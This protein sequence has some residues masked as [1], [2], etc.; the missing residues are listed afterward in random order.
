MEAAWAV[1]LGRYSGQEDIVFGATVSGHAAAFERDATMLGLFINNLPVRTQI[2]PGEAFLAWAK[3]FQERTFAQRRYEHIPVAQIQQWSEI[4]PGSRLFDSILVVNYETFAMN[5]LSQSLEISD[6]RFLGWTNFPLSLYIVL[7]AHDAVLRIKYDCRRF[8]QT[9][10]VQL[11]NH[12]TTLLENIAANPDQR[13]AALSLLNQTEHQRLLTEWNPVHSE[14]TPNIGIHQI[15][16]A[17]AARTPDAV[18]VLTQPASLTYHEL[19]QRANRLA[20]YLQAQRVRPETPIALYIEH[21]PEIVVGLLG[22]WKSGGTLLPLDPTHPADYITALLED[23]QV[24]IVVT[25]HNLAANLPGGVLVIALDTDDAAIARE[26]DDNPTSGVSADN[27]AYLNYV[28]LPVGRPGGV[29]LEHRALH[30]LARTQQQMFEL[31]SDSRILMVAPLG[32]DLALFELVMA[33]G[34]GATLCMAPQSALLPGPGLARLLHEQAITHITLSA[35]AL[36]AMPFTELPALRTIAL[37]EAE[38]AIENLSHWMAKYHCF[39][40]YGTTETTVC[41]TSAAGRADNQRP[42]IGRPVTG[43]Q[44]YI[45]DRYRQLLPVGITGELYIG[46][47]GLARGYR[48]HPALTAG[49]FIPHP[50]STEPGARLYRTGD[51]AR[52]TPD[53]TIELLGRSDAQVKLRGLRA[54]PAEVEAILRRHP[55][56]QQAA[57]VARADTASGTYLVA[58]LV[59]VEAEPGAGI[60]QDI[61]RFLQTQLPG[62]MTPDSMLLLESLPCTG[63][64]Q[65]DYQALPTPSRT[66]PGLA[67][68]Y[69]APRTETE[70]TI[71]AIWQQM[72]HID[73][74]GVDDNF[75][76]LG[77]HSLLMVQVHSE[78]QKVFQ[79]DI[80]IVELFNYATVGT[81]ANYLSQAQ[82]TPASFEQSQSRAANR[83]ESLLQ[84]RQIRRKRQ[85]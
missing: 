8:A 2:V 81:L 85:E 5:E 28:S 12:F 53:G 6:T 39:I 17:H 16:E 27:L 49:K 51:L 32:L 40:L 75:F 77:G 31:Q 9:A 65:L 66:R 19:N 52:Y 82:Q 30:H 4:A 36:Q 73:K 29:A 43:T 45:L 68:S 60:E 47:A 57:V 33:L 46:G 22:I 35:A 62:G 59:P 70:K 7:R 18:A 84:Q 23:A 55:A 41:A 3:A 25:Q 63:D 38:H 50:F 71:A 14:K 79:R 42:I 83:R 37:V 15:I 64:G 20:H 10:I 74:V 1:L 78:L 21:T 13:I 24:P 80:P 11:L 34:A 61:R 26:P 72:L 56:V 76:D 69:I 67:T 44:A 48:N 58:Y 54:E